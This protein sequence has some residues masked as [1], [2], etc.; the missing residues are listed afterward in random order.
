MTVFVC[1]FVCIYGS[2]YHL[3]E[4]T[5]SLCL[6][7]SYLF[8]LTWWSPVPLIFLQKSKFHSSLWLRNTSLWIYTTFLLFILWLINT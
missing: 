3:W 2:R 4:K 6:H 7:E 5:F 1:F 8:C